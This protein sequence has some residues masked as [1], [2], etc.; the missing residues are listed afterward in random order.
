MWGAFFVGIRISARLNTPVLFM[1][2]FMERRAMRC[3][4]E[5]AQPKRSAAR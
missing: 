1:R 3:V 2:G 5:V 4:S